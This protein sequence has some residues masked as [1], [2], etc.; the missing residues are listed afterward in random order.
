MFYEVIV[1]YEKFCCCCCCSCSLRCLT[2]FI[3]CRI[4]NHF[5]F[6]LINCAYT[7]FHWVYY[8][9]ND[10]V[11]S[12]IIFMNC[13]GG[14][15]LLNEAL[16]S[17]SS[18]SRFSYSLPDSHIRSFVFFYD[19]RSFSSLSHSIYFSVCYF[20]PLAQLTFLLTMNRFA[21][22]EEK[23]AIECSRFSFDFLLFRAEK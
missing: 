6:L 9:F 18:S 1:S 19:L 13:V 15:L 12:F 2:N 14:L 5:L 17:S 4:W 3:T 8:S 16:L 11:S 10:N 20:L 22:N 21:E 23:I 7:Q